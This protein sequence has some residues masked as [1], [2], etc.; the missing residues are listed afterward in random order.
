M[1]AD[2]WTQCTAGIHQHRA[3]FQPQRLRSLEE[4]EDSSVTT[5]ASLTRRTRRLPSARRFTPLRPCPTGCRSPRRL[6]G[7]EGHDD[8]F[9]HPMGFAHTTDATVCHPL[10]KCVTP[11]DPAL[12]GH[13]DQLSDFI[14]AT[15]CHQ[16]LRIFALLVQAPSWQST[17]RGLRVSEAI[18]VRDCT[19]DHWRPKVFVRFVRAKPSW[20]SGFRDLVSAEPS[21]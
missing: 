9:K 3:P 2:S 16:K 13:N 7:H 17:D 10:E 1:P 18:V 20:C 15:V 4:Q 21:W 14:L 5:K 8:S 19:Q 12:R 6:R 11:G